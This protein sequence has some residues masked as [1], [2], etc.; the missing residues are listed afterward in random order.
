[1]LF[2]GNYRATI[3]TLYTTMIYNLLSKINVLSNYYDIPQA[4][5]L[6]AEISTKKIMRQNLHNGRTHYYKE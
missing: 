1:M 6:I 2:N 3:V 5:D 4:K